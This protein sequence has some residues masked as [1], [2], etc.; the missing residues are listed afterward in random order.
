MKRR[1]WLPGLLIIGTVV[2]VIISTVMLVDAL[3]WSSESIKAKR[4]GYAVTEGAVLV[5]VKAKNR[6]DVTERITC[7]AKLHEADHDLIGAQW[8]SPKETPAGEWRK[9]YIVYSEQFV[10]ERYDHWHLAKC[11]IAESD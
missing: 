8:S 6:T 10:E 11:L 2:A 9:H 5:V 3:A 4:A 1:L 7:K